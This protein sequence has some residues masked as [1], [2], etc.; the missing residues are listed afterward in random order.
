VSVGV[1]FAVITDVPIPETVAISPFKEITPS[2]AD[3]YVN[4]PGVVDVG[5]VR[6]KLAS[7]M[8]LE[9]LFQV[10]TGVFFNTLKVNEADTVDS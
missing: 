6:V 5:G 3:V 1:K 10:S 4:V 8:L 9:T 7:P 2:V